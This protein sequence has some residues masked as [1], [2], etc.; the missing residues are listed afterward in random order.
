MKS[1]DPF[2]RQNPAGPEQSGR[3][4]DCPVALR[5][6]CLA[7]AIHQPQSR[8][9]HSARDRL[10]VKTT[11]GDIRVLGRAF[12]AHLENRHRRIRPVVGDIP[13][14]RVPRP[15][16]GAVYERIAM[17]EVLFVGHFRQAILAGGDIG[18]HLRQRRSLRIACDDDES[19][20]ALHNRNIDSLTRSYL[21]HRGLVLIGL[22]AGQKFSYFLL[23]ALQFHRHTLCVVADRAGQT[24]RRSYCVHR[25]PKADPLHLPGYEYFLSL[26]H[27]RHLRGIIVCRMGKGNR[28]G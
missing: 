8:P 6:D 19:A 23:L 13:H 3:L 1:A 21:R 18:G 5:L 9:T 24:K 25:R 17:P 28:R 26:N 16:V 4:G 20:I 10:S 14:Y 12:V 7:A 15:A 2:Y 22:Q 27:Q 11:V